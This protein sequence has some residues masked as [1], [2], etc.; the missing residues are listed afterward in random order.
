MGKFVC[1]GR[2]VVVDRRTSEEKEGKTRICLNSGADLNIQSFHFVLSLYLLTYVKHLG[3]F[4]NRGTEE[5]KLPRAPQLM[6]DWNMENGSFFAS[7]KSL[8]IKNHSPIKLFTNDFTSYNMILSLCHNTDV[9]IVQQDRD[10]VLI[11]V[12]D[13]TQSLSVH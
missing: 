2:C 7:L 10:H 4:A 1:D 5:S 11:R 12:F 13:Y 8:R 3:H 6:L 9:L